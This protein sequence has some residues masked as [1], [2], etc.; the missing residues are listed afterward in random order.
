ME[1]QVVHGGEVSINLDKGD[2]LGCKYGTSMEKRR[3]GEVSFDIKLVIGA[4]ER[5]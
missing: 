1:L 3:G 5:K 2:V 4:N